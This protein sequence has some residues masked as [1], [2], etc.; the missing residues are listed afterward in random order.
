[1]M[2]PLSFE[3]VKKAS[4]SKSFCRPLYDS[5]CFSRIPG[6]I[7]SLLG[8]ESKTKLPSDVFGNALE[9]FDIVILFFVD[10]FGWESFEH[11]LPTIPFLKRFDLEG[12]ASKL[13]SQ[14]PSTTAAHVTCINT[15]LD[16]GQSGVYE[17]YYYEPVV[18]QVI[19]PILFSFAGDK[20]VETLQKAGVA[21]ST[22]YPSSTIYQ[23]LKKN[24]V[25]SFIMQHAAIAHSSY[26]QAMFK[27]AAQYPYR[28]L[29][30]ALLKIS[31][32]TSQTT[33]K[34]AYFYLYFDGI[35]AMG[36]RHGV[37]SKQF[38]AAAKQCFKALEDVFMNQ[39]KNIR[40]KAACI[41]TADHGM[42]AVDPRTAFYLNKEFSGIEK[43]IKKNRKGQLIAPA[44]S[45][46]DLFLHIQEEHL[47]ETEKSLE[48]MTRGFAEV[49]RT[50][51]LIEQGFF[52]TH[53]PSR[54]FLS[55]VGN[56]VI[57][58]YEAEA[59]WWYE[60]GRFEQHFFAAH[61]GLTRKEMEIPFLFLPL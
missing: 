49:Y 60:K 46:R 40:K 58:P 20:N 16:V 50:D 19:A 18:D 23:D 38:D 56:L 22:I 35:D 3:A 29:E 37:F 7:K 34:K 15:G 2:N 25:D 28:T 53:P 41:V 27:D 48:K 1:M 36:H 5:Y 4:F 14:F 13:T 44:G 24:D 43:V 26:S 9:E 57:L 39:A 8:L 33:L 45:C 42:V 11:Y 52:G 59:V 17:W 6:T 54:E 10:G 32:L 30:E 55:R 12:C 31:D 47:E 21:A 51:A 61:G